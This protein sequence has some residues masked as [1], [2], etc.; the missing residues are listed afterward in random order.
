[1]DDTLC[2]AFFDQPACPAQRQYEALR[3]VFIDGLSQS[4]AAARFGYSPDAFRQLVHQF[5]QDI[6]AGAPPPFSSPNGEVARPAHLGRGPGN[7]TPPTSPT[8]AS[9]T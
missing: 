2:Q 9:W 1:M 5:R 4:D 7:P 6:A 8:S 3:S